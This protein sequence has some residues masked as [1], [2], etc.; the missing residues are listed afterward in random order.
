[1]SFSK[2]SVLVPTRGRLERLGRFIES[3]KATVRDNSTAELVF[4]C[5]TDD[6]ESVRYLSQYDWPILVGPRLQGYRS[7]PL[8]YNDMARV[9]RGDLLACGNDDMLFQTPDWPANVL[10]V[11]NRYPD[12]VFNLGVNTGL[13]DDKFPFSI[14]SRKVHDALGLINDP[15]LLFSDIF[16]R[17]LMG[18][19]DRNIRVTNV[20]FFHDW[21]GHGEADQTRRDANQHEF[22]MVFADTTGAWTEE[23]RELNERVV[24]ESVNKIARNSDIRPSIALMNFESYRPPENAD[25]AAPW[26]PAVAPLGW[27]GAPGAQATHYHRGEVFALLR[28]LYKLPIARD[29][30]LL[31]SL[32]NGLPSVLWG[33][34]FDKVITIRQREDL[35]PQVDDGKYS[36]CSGPIGNT[37]F[38][39]GLCEQAQ[40]LDC[41]VLDDTRYAN[42]ISPYFLFRRAMRRPGVIVMF[43]TGET[44]PLH[45]GITRFAA[46]L[47]SGRLDGTTHVLHDILLP[48]GV[49]VSYELVT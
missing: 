48:G 4:R 14:T 11:A 44:T 18:H 3:F 34:L 38:L 29:T 23:Y 24:L 2:V 10:E 21:A 46:D 35:E 40:R 13:N 12:G 45:E 33:Q 28:E 1:M 8:F 7:L 39:Y 42:L 6:L 5:D 9:A 27:Q 25:P 37:R 15:R 32:N 36:V 47:R 16:L 22:D 19:F 49:G 41:L 43:N 17:D 26:P 20:M 31:S 30:V